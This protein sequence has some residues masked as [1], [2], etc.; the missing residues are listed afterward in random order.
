M[1]LLSH[2]KLLI[3]IFTVFTLCTTN[4]AMEHD[5]R[6]E[7]KQG[8]LSGVNAG[9]NI[10]QAFNEYREGEEHTITMLDVDDLEAKFSELEIGGVGGNG[11]SAAAAA[12][13]SIPQTMTRPYPA[14]ARGYEAIYDR[15]INGRL[16]YKGPAGERSFLI[17][18][19]INSS[20]EGEFNL[21]GLTY[22]NHENKIVPVANDLR[23]KVGYRKEKESESKLT[24][25]ITPKF[26]IQSGI[27]ASPGILIKRISGPAAH[28]SEI[29]ANWSSPVGIFWTWGNYDVSDFGYLT[30]MQFDE[31]STKNLYEAVRVGGRVHAAYIRRLG[32][33]VGHDIT[34]IFN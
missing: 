7:R 13:Q 33:V 19:I 5:E 4:H 26:L 23:I 27:T 16:V 29:M 21:S 1:N 17:S 9:G 25:W 2:K 34:F 28:Y 14:I 20:L 18:D 3:Y 6:A 24:V 10:S 8:N 32:R 12:P 22:K 11:G 15:F 30:T 31:I